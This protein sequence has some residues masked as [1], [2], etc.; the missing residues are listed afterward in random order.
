MDPR[1]IPLAVRTA[2]P[3]IALTAAQQLQPLVANINGA[4]YLQV[5][6]AAGNVVNAQDLLA[7]SIDPSVPA[8]RYA[9]RT[10]SVPY[11]FDD[12]STSFLPWA[13]QILNYAEGSLGSAPRGA[14]CAS[15]L[16][17]FAG[18]GDGRAYPADGNLGDI[19]ADSTDRNA[20]YAMARGQLFNGSS[21]DRSREASAANLSATVSS[22]GAQLISAP[23]EWSINSAPAANTQATATR[24][25]GGAGVRHVLTSWA[26]DLNAVNAVAA[27][28]EFVVRDGATGVGPILYRR[29]FIALAGDS[30]GFEL[31]R[32][33]IVG[34]ANTAM[35]VE[36][37]GAPGAGN[38]A[39]ISA[40]GF[41]SS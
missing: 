22:A 7:A 40:S 27:P 38:F 3:G 9:M 14:P 15:A 30:K 6:D 11:L 33:C 31:S 8:Q 2:T 26:G 36:T 37:V 29:R 21:W 10:A 20:L 39:T 35:T 16:Y 19:D 34:S 25:A 4:L 13:F 32:L 18:S 41:S 17:L 23:G 28:F 1:H 12:S 5:A 24:A